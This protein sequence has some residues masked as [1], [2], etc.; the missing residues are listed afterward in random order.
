MADTKISALSSVTSPSLT[1][2]LPIVSGGATGKVSIHTLISTVG[3]AW[4]KK[5]SGD[6][7]ITHQNHVKVTMSTV[8]YDPKG[9]WTVASN[10]FTIPAGRAGL[11]VVV[12]QVQ[13]RPY[14]ATEGFRF[15]DMLASNGG[16]FGDQFTPPDN[17][18]IVPKQLAG[19]F[20]GEVR[21]QVIAIGQ[22]SVGATVSLYAEQENAGLASVDVQ[23]YNTWFAIAG[24]FG[25]G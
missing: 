17:K 16:S 11:Y 8:A 4:V 23:A 9:Y 21:Q 6:Q 15:I 19:G 10:C 25:S 2:V 18:I 22:L 20:D 3:F 14:A 1:D 13:W 7:T 12:G 24:P 5:L